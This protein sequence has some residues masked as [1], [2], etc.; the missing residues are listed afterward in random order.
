M[1]SLQLVM[2]V[3]KHTC[4]LFIF[5]SFKKCLTFKFPQQAIL[6]SYFRN[7]ADSLCVITA[8]GEKTSTCKTLFLNAP[9]YGQTLLL[10]QSREVMQEQHAI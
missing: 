5:S 8:M 3:S 6:L 7:K 10:G 9:A 4:S 1:G 2:E